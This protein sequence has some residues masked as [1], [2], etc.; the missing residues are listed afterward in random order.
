MYVYSPVGAIRRNRSYRRPLGVLFR[1]NREWFSFR[2]EHAPIDAETSNRIFRRTAGPKSTKI[3]QYT[4]HGFIN[5]Y[6]NSKM[7]TVLIFGVF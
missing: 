2:L 4:V 3:L 1:L 6:Y 7:S 5:Q